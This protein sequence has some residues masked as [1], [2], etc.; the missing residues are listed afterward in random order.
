MSDERVSV[1]RREAPDLDACVRVLA[2][3]HESDGYPVDW[4]QD[5]AGWL[6]PPE[7]PPAWVALL[8]GTVV[9][10]ICLSRARSG[11]TAPGL[12]SGRTGTRPE[13]TAVVSRLY[14]SPKARGHGIG[15]LLLAETVR[16]ARARGL[17]PVLDVVTSDRSAAALYERQGWTLMATGEQRWGPD[18]TVQVHSY[19][20]PR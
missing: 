13:E 10:H 12:W 15:A 19:A 5:P 11:D 18:R 1:R 6:A 17:H 16:E 20:A 8:D 14:V 7:S 4:P 2:D 3:V 9:G